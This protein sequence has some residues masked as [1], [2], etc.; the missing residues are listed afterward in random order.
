MI[1]MNK[2]AMKKLTI[3]RN[4]IYMAAF[5]VNQIIHYKIKNALNLYNGCFKI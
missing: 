5:N 2:N 3:A 4:I 1:Y